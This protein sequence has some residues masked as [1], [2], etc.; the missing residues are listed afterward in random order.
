MERYN[1]YLVLKISDI[2]KY[3][4]DDKQLKLDA[5]ATCIRLGRLNDGKHDQQYVCIAADW[6]MYEQVWSMVESF[7]DGKPNEIEQLT[8][9]VRELEEENAS[10]KRDAE[11]W[12]A[13]QKR[14]Q[15]LLDRGF[16]RSPLR[17][18]AELNPAMTQREK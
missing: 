6:P 18:E 8:A 2:E 17:E 13:Y 7:V 4:S 5:L 11:Q 1:K 9:R 14:K 12:R 16:L 3:L 10:L 15:D